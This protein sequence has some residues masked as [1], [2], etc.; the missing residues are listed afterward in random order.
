MLNHSTASAHFTLDLCFAMQICS[1]SKVCWH[2]ILNLHSFAAFMDAVP[3]RLNRI[4]M[5]HPKFWLWRNVSTFMWQILHG[6]KKVIS[7]SIQDLK[8]SSISYDGSGAYLIRRIIIMWKQRNI[9][10]ASWFSLEQNNCC[11]C[12]QA[13]I[14]FSRLHQVWKGTGKT[15]LIWGLTGLLSLLRA[16]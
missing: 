5:E 6:N 11:S 14:Y 15:A 3:L 2:F 4:K 12:R 9:F 13:F 1:L 7:P 10:E 8:F 16:C